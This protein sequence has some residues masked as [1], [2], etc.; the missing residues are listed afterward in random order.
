MGFRRVLG[1]ES[2]QYHAAQPVGPGDDPIEITA[3][4]LRE[5]DRGVLLAIT[6]NPENNGPESMAA[7]YESMHAPATQPVQSVE[8]WYHQGETRFYI[9]ANSEREA[10]DIQRTITDN[11]PDTVVERIDDREEAFP[12]IEPGDSAGGAYVQKDHPKEN[13]EYYPIASIADEGWNAEQMPIAEIISAM[14]VDGDSSVVVQAVLEPLP[15]SWTDS[16]VSWLP[17]DQSAADVKERSEHESE[18]ETMT[19]QAAFG[20]NLRILTISPDEATARDRTASVAGKFD[21][22]FTHS[23]CGM[24]LK[25]TAVD[26]RTAGRQRKKMQKFIR[27]M[28]QRKRRVTT[29]TVLGHKE[30]TCIH[31]PQK[32]AGAPG[33]NWKHSSSGAQAPVERPEHQELTADDIDEDRLPPMK[34]NLEE[35]DA[36]D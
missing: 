19:S 16:W 22:K 17:D 28:T 15:D 20:V 10:D 11:Y 24:G 26:A 27:L 14:R 5:S 13:H 36:E 35:I 29:D 1:F 33:I 34:S 6:P 30:L 8:I 2:N 9:L 25:A 18:I 3:G 32:E 12:T 31:V 7:V 4:D 21:R 23:E